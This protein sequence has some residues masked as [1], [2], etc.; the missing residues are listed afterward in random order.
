[1]EWAIRICVISIVGEPVKGFNDEQNYHV[2]YDLHPK[3]VF[4]AYLPKNKI[5]DILSARDIFSTTFGRTTL[6]NIFDAVMNITI[7]TS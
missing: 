5:I 1:M 4:T 6:L 3:W 7:L 2:M